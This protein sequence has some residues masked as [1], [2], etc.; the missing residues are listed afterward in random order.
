MIQSILAALDRVE[1]SDAVI[2]LGVRWA[3][4][5]DARL[6]GISIIDQPTMLG[7][8]PAS[9]AHEQTAEMQGHWKEDEQRVEQCLR[10]FTERCEAAG[11]DSA[12]VKDVGPPA[13]RI[14]L[15]ANRHDVI[16]LS[17]HFQTPASAG[18]TFTQLLRA[19]P[20]PIVAVPRELPPGDAIGI[21]YAGSPAA[22]RALQL[23]STSGL[24]RSSQVYVV[25]LD[26]SLDEATRQCTL[27]VEYLELH[28]VD[29]QPRPLKATG[30]V[31]EQ[32]LEEIATLEVGLLV[33]G[34]HKKMFV[35]EMFVGSVTNRI[36]EE[37]TVP[38]FLYH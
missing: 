7:G 10:R 5:L 29:A 6:T 2:E 17:P 24:E 23:F 37:A 22:S 35:Q 16:L 9:P 25:S 30:S 12:V 26:D 34:A 14:L 8:A 38:L 28:G 15:E 13:E 18:D 19:A 21:A 33:L 11:V 27:A 20:R 4:R 36:L 32:L 1:N 31:A 3:Q